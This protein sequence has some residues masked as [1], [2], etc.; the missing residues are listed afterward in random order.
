[1]NEYLEN[2]YSL[3]PLDSEKKPYIYWKP[4]Q[5]KKANIEDIFGWYH[6]F[7]DLN[8]GI[9]TGNISKLAVI[10][11]DDLHLLPDLKEFLPELNKTTRVRTRRGYHYYFSLNGEQVKSTNS[12][13]GKN[14]ELKSNGTYVVAPPSIIKAHQYVYEV[15]LSEMLPIPKLLIKKDLSACGH[16]QAEKEAVSY[17]EDRNHKTFKI[18]KYHGK[19]AGCLS[20]IFSRDLAEGERNN[21]LFI[22]Y[23]LLLQN[24]NREGYAKKLII[25]KNRSLS[26][27]LTEPELKKICRKAYHYGCNGIRNK[28]A[29]IKCE[30]CEYKFKDGRLK[31]SNIL[32]KNIRILPELSNT[33]RGIVCLLGTVF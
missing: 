2:K 19:K 26:K 11:V 9:V 20:Q 29:Y 16:A 12:L 4:F 23:N 18:P 10:D 33:Q 31:D 5:Y 1:M 7:C 6:M 22:L 17:E 24:K 28:L 3:I 14:L 30:A 13:F 8:I 27:P 21:S 32:I 15:P 25:E